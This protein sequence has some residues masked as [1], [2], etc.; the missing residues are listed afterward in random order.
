MVTRLS[1]RQFGTALTPPERA[2]ALLEFVDNRSYDGIPELLIT[3]RIS[4][5]YIR[6][7]R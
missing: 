5:F 6:L 7:L 2:T 3:D 4:L 1:H